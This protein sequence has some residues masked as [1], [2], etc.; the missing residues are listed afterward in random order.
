MPRVP[1]IGEQVNG[2]FLAIKHRLRSSSSPPSSRRSAII[3]FLA[4]YLSDT[5]DVLV[6][7]RMPRLSLKHF[8]PLLADLGRR[9][10]DAR[11]HPRPRQLADVLRRLP[12][13][14][15]R[16]DRT[17]V[18]R[19]RRAR[20]VHGRRGVHRE[21]HRARAR[22]R[23]DLAATRSSDERRRRG[24]A[25]RSRSR[26]SRRPTAACSGRGF[27][28]ALLRAA[29]GR[30]ILPAPHTDLIYAVIT[31]E[32]GLF[33]AAAC[34]SALPA[35]HLARLQDGDGRAATASPS[36]SPPGSPRSSRSRC[37]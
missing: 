23:R 13:A 26:C 20:P 4:S 7:G 36:C 17:A 8:G 18:A 12:R 9:D 27:G 6:R 33:G 24:R 1:G 25:T 21:Q 5:R 11:L 14:A 28:E 32:L 35:V 19:G 34:S 16:R 10:A 37:S 3:I 31:N 2:A 22:P 30:T 15:L 29:D